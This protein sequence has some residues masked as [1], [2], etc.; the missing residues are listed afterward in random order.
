M[1]SDCLSV[2]WWFHSKRRRW[3]QIKLSIPHSTARVRRRMWDV[4]HFS[5]NTKPKEIPWNP[6]CDSRGKSLPRR[7]VPTVGQKWGD[8]QPDEKTKITVFKRLN[9][10]QTECALLKLNGNFHKCVTSLHVEYNVTRTKAT[11]RSVIL[12]HITVNID[13]IIKLPRL[14]KHHL[15]IVDD[16]SHDIINAITPGTAGQSCM[17]GLNRSMKRVLNSSTPFKPITQWSIVQGWKKKTTE[18]PAV[19]CSIRSAKHTRGRCFLPNMQR[20][21]WAL[22]LL[23]FYVQFI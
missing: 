8:S 23:W 19:L 6:S 22:D 15:H 1:P 21:A 20:C 17:V 18:R 5:Q 4:Q 9:P 3:S 7:S 13:Q 2:T 11:I 10:D 14:Q 16:V 12:L